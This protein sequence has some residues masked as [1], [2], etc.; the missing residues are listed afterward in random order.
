MSGRAVRLG[1]SVRV[2]QYL[3]DMMNQILHNIFCK[4]YDRFDVG[5][6]FMM[7]RQMDLWLMAS[8][9]PSNIIL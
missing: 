1:A 3:N 6:G 9:F 8:G 7:G 2:L 4:T 5:H